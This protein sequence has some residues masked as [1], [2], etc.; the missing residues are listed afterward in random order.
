MGGNYQSKNPNTISKSIYFD[1]VKIQL[2]IEDFLKNDTG[3][4][5]ER[6]IN[7]G[8]STGTMSSKEYNAGNIKIDIWHDITFVKILRGRYKLLT[9]WVKQFNIDKKNIEL[10]KFNIESYN[11]ASQE[12]KDAF[13]RKYKPIEEDLTLDQIKDCIN[14]PKNIKYN[15]VPKNVYSRIKTLIKKHGFQDPSVKIKSLIN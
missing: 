3:E 15:K 4:S 6:E 13:I 1:V 8:I 9:E 5:D 10:P 14:L 7:G 11:F 2:K 12:Q